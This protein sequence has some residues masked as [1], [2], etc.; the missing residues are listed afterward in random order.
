MSDLAE[1]MRR[2]QIAKKLMASQ[3]FEIT[4]MFEHG[5]TVVMEA[6]WVGTIA[7]DIGAFKQGRS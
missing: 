5:A 3:S 6:R 2:M 4:S 7:A 1:T